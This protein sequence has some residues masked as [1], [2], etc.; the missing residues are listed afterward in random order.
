[1]QRSRDM[2]GINGKRKRADVYV[3]GELV[4]LHRARVVEWSPTAVTALAATADGT[5]VAVAR[6]SGS[7]ELWNTEHWQC[8]KVRWPYSNLAGVKKRA[9]VTTTLYTCRGFRARKTQPFHV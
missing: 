4:A 9:I 5:V 2:P 3:D 8:M 7:I 6:E 1:M